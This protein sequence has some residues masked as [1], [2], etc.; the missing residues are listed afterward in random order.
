MYMMMTLTATTWLRFMIWFAIGIVVYF[1]YGMRHS[2][3]NK[4]N[5]Q[6]VFPCI[7]KSV[8]SNT[9]SGETSA[10]KLEEKNEFTQL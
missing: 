4:N 6:T 5:Q 10:E 3:E 9:E 8:A 1:G 2:L 7:E